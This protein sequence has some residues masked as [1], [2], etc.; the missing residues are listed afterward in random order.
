[1]LLKN[2]TFGR[3]RI[4]ASVQWER[5]GSRGEFLLS[6]RPRFLPIQVAMLVTS[7]SAEN[8]HFAIRRKFC[9]IA[10]RINS[11]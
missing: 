7:G 10:A 5:I 1:M 2:A 9:A 3:G 6:W 8:N 11:S 4:A